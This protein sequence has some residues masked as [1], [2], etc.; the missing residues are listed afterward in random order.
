MIGIDRW[1][2]RTG[3]PGP[4]DHRFSGFFHL[5]AAIDN[6]LPS[7]LALQYLHWVILVL[8][9]GL[10]P[11]PVDESDQFVDVKEIHQYH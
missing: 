3:K 10:H 4:T 8:G 7:V 6:T 11:V 9:G 5:K 1:N 2:K